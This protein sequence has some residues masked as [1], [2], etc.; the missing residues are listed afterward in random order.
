MC[1]DLQLE[2]KDRRKLD[3]FRI[4]KNIIYLDSINVQLDIAV[5]ERLESDQLIDKL[6]TTRL[7]SMQRKLVRQVAAEFES[8]HARIFI[9]TL[10]K[11]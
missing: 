8:S 6:S 11:T 1:N 4:E 10:D 9:K 2:Q 5:K 7:D 3:A